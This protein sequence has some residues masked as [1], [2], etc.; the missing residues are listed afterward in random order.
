[1]LR[2]IFIVLLSIAALATAGLIAASYSRHD[3]PDWYRIAESDPTYPFST[4][5]SL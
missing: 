4:W 1:M 2:R 3:E 5:N